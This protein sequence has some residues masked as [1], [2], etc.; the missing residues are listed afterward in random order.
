MC[1]ILV[2]VNAHPLY[3]LVLAANRD[4]YFSRPTR[5]ADYWEDA[6][7]VL[8]GR[9]LEAG[10]T[11]LGVE[12]LGRLAAVTNLREPPQKKPGLESRGRLVSDYL[13]SPVQPDV[14]MQDVL[15]RKDRFDAFNLLAGWGTELYF[16]TSR[17][18]FFKR[19]D[20]GIHG[21]SNG[22][23]DSPWPKI[24]RGKAMFRDC[25]DA[26]GTVAEED[27]FAILA[28]TTVAADGDLPDTGVGV[29]LERRLSPIFVHMDGYGTRCSTVVT[30]DSGGG[31][32][33]CERNFDDNGA[34]VDNGRFEFAVQ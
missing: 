8:A 12:R 4:E 5:S 32:V 19:L 10:G 33:F 29:E 24:M 23:L 11:W 20:D 26:G 1:L 6:P 18:D 13:T 21:I 30:L 15:L 25:L 16:H 28:D 3:P 31:L 27:L 17:H 14:Y 2:A 9:D 22:E 34:I 7:A